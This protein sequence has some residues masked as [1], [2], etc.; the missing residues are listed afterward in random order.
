MRYLALSLGILA[1]LGS[2]ASASATPQSPTVITGRAQSVT[3]T[4]ATLTGSIE[5]HASATSYYFNYGPTAAL[6]AHTASAVVSELPVG[7]RA[8]SVSAAISG[9]APATTYHFRLIADNASGKRE[10]GERTF[11]TPKVPLSLTIAP[12][13]DPVLYGGL[14]TI[15]GTLSGTGN[16]DQP[17]T[18]QANTFPFTQGFLSVGN[19]EL[20]SAT[21][22]FAFP[23]VGL[24]QA[25]QFRVV[26]GTTPELVSAVA[27]EDVAV[28][29]EAHLA[30]ARRR[31]HVRIFGVVKPAIDG[32]EVQIL[33]VSPGHEAHIGT[34]YLRHYTATSSRFSAVVRVH[35]HNTYRVLV[36]V[37][38][39][40]QSSNVSQPLYIK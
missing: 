14:V 3:P 21:G 31:H 33:R 18:L 11:T 2:S 19:S 26:A 7:R 29:V 12:A 35:A 15:D 40:A 4:S 23:V 27:S 30:R 1:F 28:Q 10:G 37:T 8:A 36:E 32:M 25:T 9:L 24:L 38:N 39:G 6:G 20:T 22:A 16:A 34:T 17:V 13:P 5:P